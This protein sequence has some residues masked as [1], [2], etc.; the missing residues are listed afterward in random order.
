MGIQSTTWEGRIFHDEYF[1]FMGLLAN[2]YTALAERAPNHRLSII[3]EAKRRSKG[4]GTFYAW[5]AIETGEESAPY[6]HWVD[7]RFI[8]GQ[9]SEEAWQF[10][11]RTGSKKALARYYPVLRGCAEWLNHDAVVRDD[12]GKLKIRSMTDLDEGLYPVVSGIYVTCATIRSLENAAK[13]ADLLGCDPEDAEDW[14]ALAAE[15]RRSLPVSPDGVHYTYSENADLP[16]GGGHLG[17]VFPFSIDIHSELARNTISLGYQSF[18]ESREDR[19]SDQVLAYTWMWALS[20]LA[21]TLF[22]Q[23]RADEGYE[24]L[25]QVPAVVGP[26]M[27]PNEQMRDDIGAYLTWY[28]T[29]AGIYS[30]ALTTMFV[31]VFNEN[32][33]ILLPALP[34]ALQNIRF[35]G[36][37]ATDGVTVAAE[38]SEGTINR[39]DLTSL[40]D[41]TWQFRMPKARLEQINLRKDLKVSAADEVGYVRIECRLQKGLNR[42]L[43]REQ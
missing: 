35:H 12:N 1:G 28:T 27:A 41:M 10:Y 29:G 25:S 15:L 26:F 20:Q 36:L 33:A 2:N 43:V 24:V 13:A 18:L 8:H 14:S 30:F 38:I 19:R 31:Q 32:G 22:Y 23:G 40:R 21:T 34:A 3:P 17:M 16:N 39:L 9:F 42:L 6:G 5:E 7:E 11:L 4:H 37:L